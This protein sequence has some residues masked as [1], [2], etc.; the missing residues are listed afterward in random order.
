M[1]TPFF[2]KVRLINF[3]KLSL[4]LKILIAILIIPVS[5]LVYRGGIKVYETYQILFDP[6]FVGI[7]TNIDYLTSEGGGMPF[8]L[9]DLCIVDLNEYTSTSLA[10]PKE[11]TT[12]INLSLTK[13]NFLLV[14]ANTYII[15]TNINSGDALIYVQDKS[16][17]DNLSLK[18]KKDMIQ[19]TNNNIKEY[20]NKPSYTTSFVT[21]TP[22]SRGYGDKKWL[23][24]IENFK[25]KERMSIGEW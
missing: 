10:I 5:I 22:N 1:T 2:K 9:S 25:G 6:E 15:P 7:S 18:E 19:Q 8:K 13:Y 16:I 11:L 17:W 12:K 21:C 24:Y 4:R 14:N 20:F 3:T 23:G